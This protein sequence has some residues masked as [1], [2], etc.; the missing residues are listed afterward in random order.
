MRQKR[1]RKSHILWEVKKKTRTEKEDGDFFQ[2]L[3][4]KAKSL[5][6]EKFLDSG[7]LALSFFGNYCL[8]ID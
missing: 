4:A 2:E 6:C 5:S 7:T 1:K 3:M 8:T